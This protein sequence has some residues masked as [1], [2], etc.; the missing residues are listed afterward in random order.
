[1]S[2]NFFEFIEPYTNLNSRN[3]SY[4]I[5][6]ILDLIRVC[7]TFDCIFYFSKGK[8]LWQQKMP[9][10]IVCLQLMEVPSRGGQFV[11]VA[12]ANKQILIFNDKH[13]VDC[14]V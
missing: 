8:V 6:E 1:M 5:V 2:M 3:F 14:L 9:S 7:L 13:V 10:H 4:E 12:L 11:A